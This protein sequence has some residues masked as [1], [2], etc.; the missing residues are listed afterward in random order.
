VSGP[1]VVLH[2]DELRAL[3]GAELTRALAPLA[4]SMWELAKSARA[5]EPKPDPIKDGAVTAK[6]VA[7]ALGVDRRELRRLVAAGEFP[8]PMKVGRRRIRWR[9]SEVE[10]WIARRAGR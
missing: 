6:D 5:A 10:E 8:A 9:R 3:I 2:P 7:A 4:D 1:L